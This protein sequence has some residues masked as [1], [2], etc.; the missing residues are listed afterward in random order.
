M[1]EV[2]IRHGGQ[3]NVCQGEA[4][5]DPLITPMD[6]NGTHIAQRYLSDE[7]SRDL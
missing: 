6:A 2:W 7:F 5:S 3:N 1:N 4:V